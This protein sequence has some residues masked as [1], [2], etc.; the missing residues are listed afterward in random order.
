M[1][2]DSIDSIYQQHRSAALGQVR[3]RARRSL[4]RVA[5]SGGAGPPPPRAGSADRARRAQRGDG[6]TRRDHRRRPAASRPSA[7]AC[8][9]RRSTASRPS[10]TTCSPRAA[11]ATCACAPA[12]RASPPPATRT[13]TTVE[14]RRSDS[15]LGE[16]ARG[17][18]DL[19]RRD[20]LP[21][22]LPR[23]P[24]R[25]RRRRRSTPG[26]GAIERAA[27]RRDAA[28]RRA[29]S[30]RS[31]LDEPVLTRPGDWSGLRRALDEP[32]PR[33][34][35]RRSRPPT[36]AAAAAPA[37]RPATSGSSRARPRAS[38]K[39]IV[40]NGDEGDPGSYIDKLP[41]GGQ[42]AAAARGHGAGRL[43]GRRRATASS[44]SAPSTRAPSPRWRRR[45]SAR[46]RGLLGENPRS[47]FAST[48]PS[49]RA[50]APTSSARRPRC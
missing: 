6:S 37:S 38:E 47:G 29:A 3:P 43:R 45:S 27:G 4:V 25:A 36:S 20:R 2:V 31:L 35:S 46:A 15:K 18:R 26:P 23:Q 40:A 50:P 12:R 33:S 21:R 1:R 9:R 11:R 7:R 17:R 10:T 5:Q 13:W 32:R 42:P 28:R 34:C 16:R 41:D 14:R 44:S 8:P 49:S 24:G 19:A 30:S 39:L 22:L 48:S